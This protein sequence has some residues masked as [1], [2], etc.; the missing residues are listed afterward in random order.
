MTSGYVLTH[1][2]SEA[3]EAFQDQ[4]VRFAASLED[5]SGIIAFDGPGLDFMEFGTVFMAEPHPDHPDTWPDWAKKAA[6][7]RAIATG[8]EVYALVGVA[9]EEYLHSLEAVTGCVRVADSLLLV[10]SDGPVSA[11]AGWASAVMEF[12][13][14]RLELANA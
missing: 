1:E 7:K 3:L 6:P 9:F 5:G 13:D 8:R 11:G 2:G 12:R 4:R 10:E 14:K